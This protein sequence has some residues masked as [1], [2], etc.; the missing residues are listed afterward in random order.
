MRPPEFWSGDAEGRDRAPMLQALLAPVSWL[1]AWGAAQRW[2]ATTPRHAPIPVVCVG[3][4]TVGGAGKTPVSRAIR[5]RLNALGGDGAH[6]LSRGYGGRLIGP[7]RVSPDMAAAEVG[8]EP[9][10]HAGDGPAWIARDRLAGA[11]AAAQAG[12]HVLVMDDGFQNP[13]LAKDLSLLVIDAAAGLGNGRVLPAGPLR[14]NL[15]AGLA[16]ADAAILLSSTKQEHAI[17]RFLAAFKPPILRAHLQPLAPPPSGKLIA[18]AGIGRPEKFFATLRAI[19]AE[20]VDGVGFADHHAF[21]EDEV[22]ALIERAVALEALPVTTA[23]DAVRLPRGARGMVE[24]VEVE[25][26]FAQPERLDGLLARALG[27]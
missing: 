11:L 10:M 17:P 6:T 9:L 26:E 2:R 27:G 18:F 7:L 23:K 19:G 20:V 5:A 14:E 16:R 3:N 8:D 12:A 15:E 13:S 24:V 22:M 1:Y 4:L 25:V 21:A